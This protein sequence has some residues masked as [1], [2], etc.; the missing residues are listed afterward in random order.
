VVDLDDSLRP[1]PTS[2]LL[3]VLPSLLSTLPLPAAI[4]HPTKAKKSKS[5]ASTKGKEKMISEADETDVV[6]ALDS[7]DCGRL[8]ALSIAGWFGERVND[9]EGRWKFEVETIIREL[10]IVLL[11][12]GGVSPF[13]KSSQ[14]PKYP[15]TDFRAI[16]IVRQTTFRRF[17]DQ[18]ERALRGFRSGLRGFTSLGKAKILSLSSRLGQFH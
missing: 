3:K 12:D 8:I 14:I 4:A 15:V 17:L 13:F 2:F 10:G 5:V 9:R 6:D 16:S 18:V 1:V 11:A 7:V